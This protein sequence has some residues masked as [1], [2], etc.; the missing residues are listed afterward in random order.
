MRVWFTSQAQRGQIG[1]ARR[2]WEPDGLPIPVLDSSGRGLQTEEDQGPP[3]FPLSPRPTGGRASSPPSAVAP[4]VAAGTSGPSVA[5]AGRR[6]TMSA[7]RGARGC[8]LLR[9]KHGTNAPGTGGGATT[10]RGRRR[11]QVAPVCR[12]LAGVLAARRSDRTSSTSWGDCDR[13]CD[14]PGGRRCSPVEGVGSARGASLSVRAGGRSCAS[15]RAPPAAS[16]RHD[17]VN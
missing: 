4:S 17:S 10:S 2:D 16:A 5:I 11:I 6:A 15:G 14:S 9:H 3:P 7:S 13:P 1:V 8:A 12:D